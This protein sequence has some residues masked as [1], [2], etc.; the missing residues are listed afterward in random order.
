[1]GSFVIRHSVTHRDQ[2]GILPLTVRVPRA[3][4]HGTGI[5]HYLVV[6]SEG[7]WRIKGFSKVFPSLSA[8]VVHHSVMK[9]HLPCRLVVESDRD[10]S[11]GDG[12]SDRES[13]FADIDSEPD[14]PIIVN[15]LREQL[16]Q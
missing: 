13:D 12:D 2:P 7:G 11:L 6:G 15:R 8:L 10:S 5:L 3:L 1:M 14:F 4:N 9:E 16:S